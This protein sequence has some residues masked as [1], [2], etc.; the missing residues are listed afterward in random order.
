MNRREFGTL[1]AGSAAALAVPVMAAQQSPTDRVFWR[2]SGGKGGPGR[3]K[4][5][6][7]E[8]IDVGDVV[9]VQGGAHAWQVTRWHHDVDPAKSTF[10]A[11]P[12]HL[13][14]TGAP[15]VQERDPPCTFKTGATC[16]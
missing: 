10:L 7:F 14:W 8:D 15:P 9:W 13:S 1:I 4:R 11:E 16:L 3:W 12:M 6:V 2:M 5:V